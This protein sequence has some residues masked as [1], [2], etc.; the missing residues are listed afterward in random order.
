MKI[1]CVGG[2][3]AGLYFAVLAKLRN[4]YHDVTVVERNP[5]GVTYGW[6]V[7]FWDDLLD[8]LYRNDPVSAREVHEVSALWG[9]QEVHIRGGHKA[10]LGGYGYSL[11][12]KRLLDIL[13]ARARD[14]GV[15]VQ[16]ERDIKNLSE[17]PDADLIIAC[18]GVNSSIRQLH[19]D[20]FQ[21]DVDVGRNKYIWLGTNRVFDS[22]TF[23]FEETAAGW[24]WFHAYCFD[25]ETSTLIVECSPETWAGLGFDE[26]EP[27]QSVKLLEEIFERHLNHYSLINRMP[28]GVDKALW[29]NFRRISNNNWYYD[30]VVLMGDAAHTTHFAIGSGTKLAIADAIALAKELDAHNDLPSALHAYQEYRRSALHTTQQDALNSAKWFEDVPRYIDQQATTQFAYSLWKRRGKYSLWRYQLHLATQIATLRRLRQSVG[31]ARREIRARRRVKLADAH[32]RMS[33]AMYAK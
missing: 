19:S 4:R 29:L 20:H 14:L 8:E 24:I 26:L 7:V 28:R 18:D 10:Y 23:A 21:T 27:D 9:G 3:P 33:A 16:F 22:F 6:G 2:G 25:A 5:A 1:V 31:A 17:F 12:R 13:V 11:G 15:D 30:N 32:E